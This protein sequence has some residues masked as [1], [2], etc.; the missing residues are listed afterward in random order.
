MHVVWVCA[1]SVHVALDRRP[2]QSCACARKCAWCASHVH[3]WH[4]LCTLR[5]SY[6]GVRLCNCALSWAHGGSSGQC[7]RVTVAMHISFF[8]C[9]FSP[10]R[11]KMIRNL[12]MQCCDKRADRLHVAISRPI[13]CPISCPISRPISRQLV[14]QICGYLH[15]SPFVKKDFSRKRVYQPTLYQL[16]I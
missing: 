11:V 14:V 3:Q 10:S 16:L 9:E 5:V 12:W 6:W 13:S 15:V 7:A 4:G 1:C 8:P 2:A